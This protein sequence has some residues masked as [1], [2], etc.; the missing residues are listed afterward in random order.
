MPQVMQESDGPRGLSQKIFLRGGGNLF[1]P[2]YQAYPIISQLN[3]AIL[4]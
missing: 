1:L 2:T 4:P 3:K